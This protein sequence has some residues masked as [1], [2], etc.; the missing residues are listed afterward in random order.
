MPLRTQEI[1]EFEGFAL[2]PGERT[3]TRAGVSLPLTPKAFDTLAYLVR[4]PGKMLSKDELLKEIWPDTFVEEV[5]LAVNISTLRKVLGEEPQDRRFIVTVAGKGYRFVAS[6]SRRSS[7]ESNGPNP[8][9]VEPTSERVADGGSFRPQVESTPALGRW[10]AGIFLAVLAVLMIAAIG[11]ILF[12]KSQRV[13]RQPLVETNSVAVLPFTDLSQSKDQEYFSDGLSEELINELGKVPGLKVVPRSSAFQFKGRNEDVRSVGKRLGVANVLEGSVHREGNRIRISAELTKAGDGFQLWS[14]TYDRKID[15]IFAVQD[16][17]SR[18]VTSA[19]RMKLLAPAGG[20]GASP[21]RITNPEAY[22]AYLQSQYFFRRG[23]DRPDLEKAITYNDQAIKLD[24]NYAP[25]WALR[26]SILTTMS[27]LGL[28]DHRVG[29]TEARQAAERA[30]ALDPQLAADYVSLA[31]VQLSYEWDWAGADASLKK[32]AE[33]DPGDLTVLS[34]RSYLYECLGKIDEAI[35]MTQQATA[36]DP[37]RANLYLGDLLYI[38]GRYDEATAALEKG[39][40]INPKLEGAH[41]NLSQILIAK[42]QPELALEEIAKEPGEWERL[43]VQAITYY[44]LGRRKE[45]DAALAKLVA[46]HG[47]DSPYQVAQ[48]HAHRGETSQAFEWL[49][50]AYR[51]HDPGLNQIKSDPLLTPLRSEERYKSLLKRMRL[52]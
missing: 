15:D 16:E 18:A 17:I 50:R 40:S 7:S 51:E 3:L 21:S 36:L 6:V 41:S 37:E 35:A 20:T 31:W 29:Y 38:A 30:I 26:S 10:R 5:N 11:S 9:R 8:A 25:A 19:L 32:A 23:E 43:T 13:N 33:L 4:N 47:T 14:E 39:L 12:L 44:D 34:Y 42:H 24:G 48:V 1:F 52:G 27:S 28:R 22:E 45:S 49:E 2:D 46:T